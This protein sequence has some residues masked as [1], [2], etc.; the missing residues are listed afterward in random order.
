MHSVLL[1]IQEHDAIDDVDLYTRRMHI[2]VTCVCACVVLFDILE[3][4]DYATTYVQTNLYLS[5]ALAS[6]HMHSYK[7]KSIN[8]SS[9]SY[10][11]YLI[12]ICFVR[13]H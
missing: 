5:S 6:Q 12:F 9:C 7:H 10:S 13:A 8:A 2:P 1:E 11:A 4:S 3:R